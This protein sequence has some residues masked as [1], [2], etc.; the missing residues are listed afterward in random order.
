MYTD[1][2]NPDVRLVGGS[3]NEGRLEIMYSGTFHSVCFYYFSTSQAKV[4]CRL[5]GLDDTYVVPNLQ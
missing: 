2:G 5:L 3:S 1:A 4:M